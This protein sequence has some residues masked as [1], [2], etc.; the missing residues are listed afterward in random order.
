MKCCSPG[1]INQHPTYIVD[2]GEPTSYTRLGV[3]EPTF[4]S[5]VRVTAIVYFG[6]YYCSRLD[7]G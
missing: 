7:V 4:M 6:V 3:G 1:T 2:V 5:A